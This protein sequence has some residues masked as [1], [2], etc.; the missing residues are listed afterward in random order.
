MIRL[1]LPALVTMGLLTMF[2]P[3]RQPR[4]SRSPQQGSQIPD[5][6]TGPSQPTALDAPDA[7]SATPRDRETP[8]QGTASDTAV[9]ANGSSNT[10]SSKPSD[11]KPSDA[12]PSDAKPSGDVPDRMARAQKVMSELRFVS[13]YIEHV[14]RGHAIGEAPELGCEFTH[15]AD[16]AL[17]QLEL[18]IVDYTG[19][20]TKAN[21][22]GT[23]FI[24]LVVKG[25]GLADGVGAKAGRDRSA[26]IERY[27]KLARLFELPSRS[28]AQALGGNRC[29]DELDPY[30]DDELNPF[31][32]CWRA[33]E[34]GM[35]LRGATERAERLTTENGGQFEFHTTFTYELCSYRS[36]ECR[37]S[38]LTVDL[39][40]RVR[41]ELSSIVPATGFKLDTSA[42]EDMR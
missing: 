23:P 9:G 14:C 35:R 31:F 29:H 27:A 7:K 41:F 12:K 18:G 17:Q 1:A 30:V 10:E 20:V 37:G 25:V 28:E 39:I 15:E 32:A 34:S 16:L 21:L 5:E 38:E 2:E 4:P 13:N 40:A 26:M 33:L 3:D 6:A 11:A 42:S 36:A 22:E 24:T 19:T 8:A